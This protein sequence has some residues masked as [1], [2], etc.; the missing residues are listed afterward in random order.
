MDKT[1]FGDDYKYTPKGKE[2][3]K[4]EDNKEEETKQN[5]KT[6]EVDYSK[7]GASIAQQV[8]NGMTGEPKRVPKKPYK[9]KIDADAFGF[10]SDSEENESEDE[11]SAQMAALN[12]LFKD[13]DKIKEQ[14][15]AENRFV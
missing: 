11:V 8:V 6:P 12:S 9:E 4:V 14:S 13:T 3:K 2:N 1:F 7:L 15:L 5:G 10:A